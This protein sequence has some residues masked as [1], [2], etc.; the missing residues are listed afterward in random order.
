MWGHSESLQL[1]CKFELFDFKHFLNLAIFAQEIVK[2]R[3]ARHTDN[4]EP[5]RW[6]YT[7]ILYLELL[8]DFKSHDGY[9]GL[10]IG[11]SEMDW[12]LEFTTNS[13]PVLKEFDAESPLVFYVSLEELE[14]IKKAIELHE[15]LILNHPNPYWK[16]NNAV[17]IK[18]PDGFPVIIAT[19]K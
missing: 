7:E 16:K 8:G 14:V 1:K 4:L 12:H 3:Y 9:D 2:F 18:D 5:L 13:H 10:F 19:H 17:F 15:I 6:F 11:R